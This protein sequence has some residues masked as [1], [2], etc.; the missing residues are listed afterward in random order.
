MYL[1][2]VPKGYSVRSK[3]KELTKAVNGTKDKIGFT[4]INK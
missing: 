2:L 1:Q 4:Y 3:A